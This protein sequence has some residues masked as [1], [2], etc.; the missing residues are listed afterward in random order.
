MKIGIVG[1]GS[2]AKRVYLPLYLNN[3]NIQ[4]INVYGRNRKLLEQKLSKYSLNIFDELDE[5]L[6]VID[7][8]MVHSA[9]ESHHSIIKKALEKHIPV[10]V[11]K[12][13]TN[14]LSLSKELINL[15]KE[16]DTLLFVGYNRRYAPLYLKVKEMGLNPYK[17]H[18]E[19]HRS[20]LTT[21]ENYEDA[22]IDD[23]IH[24]IDTVVDFNGQSLKVSDARVNVTNKN[25]LLSLYVNLSNNKQINT[26]FTTR[27]ST[28]DYEKITIHEKQRVITVEDMRVLK[29]LENNIETITKIN[30]RFSDSQIRGF[31][32]ALNTF[33]DMV[34]T[35]KFSD[36][37]QSESE[38]LCLDVI[39]YLK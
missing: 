2:I 15:A 6:S 33:Y 5:M 4:E 22:I 9:T 21:D 12:P 35:N 20:I 37:K 13:L 16:T 34:K 36:T 27:D 11:D 19:K 25:E 24:L 29:I 30:E 26:L 10:Y 31:E 7:C 18:Y 1:F 32:N 14:A 38:Q 28:N 23:F 3:E 39:N 8:L 17:I